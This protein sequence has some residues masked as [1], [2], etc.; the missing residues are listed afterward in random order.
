MTT[1]TKRK[2]SLDDST[3]E[4]IVVEP[5]SVVPKSFHMLAEKIEKENIQLEEVHPPTCVQTTIT[6]LIK[7]LLVCKRSDDDTE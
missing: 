1:R 4:F 3:L 6:Y 7:G 5:M 2:P